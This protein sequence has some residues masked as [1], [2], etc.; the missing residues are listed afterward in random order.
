MMRKQHNLTEVQLENELEIT[1]L[2]LV[3]YSY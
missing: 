1:L 3:I 2:N